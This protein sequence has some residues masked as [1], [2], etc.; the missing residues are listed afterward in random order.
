VA[1][2]RVAT[3][4]HEPHKW[5]CISCRSN[6]FFCCDKRCCTQQN[7]TISFRPFLWFRWNVYVLGIDYIQNPLS[8]L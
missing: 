7:T 1:T 2:L 3:P 6:W 4:K 5:V 8:I